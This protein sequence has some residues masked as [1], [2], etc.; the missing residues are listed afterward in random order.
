MKPSIYSK[1]KDMCKRKS[2]KNL[3]KYCKS[4]IKAHDCIKTY[5]FRSIIDVQRKWLRSD[6]RVII[7]NNT[8]INHQLKYIM[9]E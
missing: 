6:H 8:S 4:F 2:K 7:Y 3:I 5:P 9:Y 1:N